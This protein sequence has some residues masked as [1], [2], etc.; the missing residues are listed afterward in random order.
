LARPLGRSIAQTRGADPARQSPLDG[1]LRDEGEQNCHIHL[2]NAAFVTRGNL[3][4]SG[5]GTGDDLIKPKPAACCR[6]DERGAVGRQSCVDMEAGTMI[7]RRRFIGVFFHGMRTTGR[8]LSTALGGPL[9]PAAF[10]PT[11]N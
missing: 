4:D 9:D 2:S 1:S 10:S 5:D 6:C 3:L 11:T 8:S 7:S